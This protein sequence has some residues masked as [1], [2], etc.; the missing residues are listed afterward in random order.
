MSRPLA[1]FLWILAV[2]AVLAAA[3]PFVA[4][5]GLKSYYEPS[6]P[7][8]DRLAELQ[9]QVP[10]RIYSRDGK[11]IGEFGAERRNPLTY[12]EIP[13][14][15]VQAFLAA[16]DDRFFEHPGVD[17]QGLVRAAGQLALTGRRAQ[18]GSTITMQLARN[19]FLTPE[20]S[21]ERKI[22]EIFLAL[23]IEKTLDKPKILEIYLNKIFLG[24]RAYG[25]GAASQVYFGR[26]P[27]ELTWGQAAILAGLPKAPSRD[28]PVTSPERARDRRDYVLRRLHELDKISDQDFERA[29]AE[30]VR[31]DTAAPDVEAEAHYVAE[32]V[33]SQAIARYGE[34]AYTLGL[35]ITATV[36]S[37]RQAAANRA[38]RNALLAY[39][40][41]HGWRGP[42]A[43]LPPEL[44][45]GAPKPNAIDEFLEARPQVEGLRPA[46]VISF[47][48]DKI[49]L[50]ALGHKSVEINSEDFKWAKLSARKPLQRG[51][52]V[53]VRIKNDQ[54]RLAQIP[55]AQGALAA[56]DPRT[57]A[58][59]AVAGG[60]DFQMNKYNRATQAQRQ[61]GSGFK[62]FVY[63]AAFDKGM[64]P[65]SV[66]LDA[67][68]VYEN[69]ELEGAW[70]PENSDHIFK[71]P[72]RLREALVQSRNL[73]SIRL[74]QE[75]G[76]GYARNYITRFG[77]EKERIPNNLS[78][79]LGT[80]SFTPMEMAEAYSIIAN[81]GF[82]VPPYIIQRIEDSGGEVLYEARPP[83]ICDD[84]DSSSKQG[85]KLQDS[86]AR[87]REISRKLSL[88][89]Q[90]AAQA[91]PLPQSEDEQEAK[92]VMAPRIAWL[93]G[94]VLRDVTVRGTGARARKLGRKDIAGK[95][96]TTNDETDAWFNGFNSELVAI[97]W[98]GF[99]QPAPMGRGEN[100]SRAALPMWMDFMR[101]ALADAP[102]DVPRRPKGLA[103]VRIDKNSGLLASAGNPDTITEVVQDDRIP[104]ADYTRRGASEAVAVEELF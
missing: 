104:Q 76:V 13:P 5:Y 4:F 34:Q 94:D 48:P 10:L 1:V 40:E 14:K 27:A 70:R 75:I 97:C 58:I 50:R 96:G 2:L 6:L 29:L 93:I 85:P 61:P 20:R 69:S 41:R 59:E 51:D 52:V 11:L 18:G 42:E 45:E 86:K 26:E 72:M 87:Q 54:W 79:S 28:N 17:W 102:Q 81:G 103:T 44:I 23:R 100:G 91:S 77:F 32:M 56:V 31:V 98:V 80:G 22:R 16:E 73:V 62:P 84:C 99:D 95:T 12:S 47:S 78:M 38:L 63:A 53:R 101:F 7:S 9:L 33:R 15:I 71:G 92:R 66:L 55:E 43:R 65:A 46:A 74:L 35:S 67:P 36:D 30:P 57:G 21:Y 68:I 8:V 89:P 82:H 24:Q 37:E 60:Y 3:T 49:V 25:V 39:D 90:T 19:V 64:T 83:R 88:G